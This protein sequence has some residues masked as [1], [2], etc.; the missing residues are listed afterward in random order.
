MAWMPLGQAAAPLTVES[1]TPVGTGAAPR[2]NVLVDFKHHLAALRAARV[3]HSHSPATRGGR[4]CAAASCRKLAGVLEKGGDMAADT[5]TELDAVAQSSR[6]SAAAS[7]RP[8]G[9]ALAPA[10]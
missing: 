5:I 6:R 8:V 4:A 3:Y 2:R 7:R 10:S 9:G 1:Q